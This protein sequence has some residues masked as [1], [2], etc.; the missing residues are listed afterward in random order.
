[1]SFTLRI[2]IYLSSRQKS[3]CLFVVVAFV[4]SGF[5]RSRNRFRKGFI[6]QNNQRLLAQQ[7]GMMNLLAYLS[8][9]LFVVNLC[10][11]R[12]VLEDNYDPSGIL[13]SFEFFTGPDPTNGFVEY[14]DRDTAEREGLLKV[15]GDSLYMGVDAE[16]VT[17]GGRPSIRITSR[18]A[19]NTGLVIL[20]LSHMPGGVCGTWPAFWSFGPNWPQRYITFSYVLVI[21][22]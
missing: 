2:I 18:K 11:A 10:A 9:L 15:V 5:S 7:S 6:L 8:L 19:Y 3:V 14:V 12:F 20:D 16:R 1:M 17:P 22:F 13:D 4:I 21:D